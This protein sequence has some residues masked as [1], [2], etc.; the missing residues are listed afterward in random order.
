MRLSAAILAA[1]LL[2]SPSPAQVVGDK[3]KAEGFVPLFNGKDLGGWKVFDAKKDGWSAADG[4]IVFADGGGGWLGTE[5][6]YD[7]FV[8]R[9]DYRLIPGGN[10]G[11]YLR[12]PTSGWISRQGMEIQLLDDN[13][14]RYAKLDFYQYTGSIYHVVPPTR[15]V[16]KPGG[17]WNALEIQAKGRRVVVLHNGVK[18]VDADL[19]HCLRD[20]AV[21]KEHPGLKRATGRIGLQAHTDRVEFRNLRVKVLPKAAKKG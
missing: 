10:S 7:N 16:G 5:R 18:I 19:D 9:L 15:R 13:H 3:E 6:D 17:Q 8:L 12:A 11:V 2:T 21:A 4:K 20:P 14:P 1:C